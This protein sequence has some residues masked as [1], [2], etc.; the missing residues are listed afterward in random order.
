V[1]SF[2]GRFAIALVVVTLFSTI[3]FVGGQAYGR[4][5]FESESKV[6]HLDDGVLAPV[7]AGKPAN[8]LLLGSDV[9]PADETPQEAA[10]Y[11]TA[12]DTGGARSDVMMILHLDPAAHRSMLVSFPRDLVVQIPGHGLNLLN[13]AYGFGGPALVI[14]TLEQNFPPMKVNHYLEV[15]FRGFKKIVNTIGHVNIYFPTPAN[16]EFTGLHV[17]QA[18]C[19]SLN[20]DEALAY[21]RSRHYNIPSD[22]RNPAPWRPSGANM[23]SPGWIQDGR[24]DLDRIPRQQYFLRTLSRA[25]VK[26]AGTD[27]LGIN[28]L[29]TAIFKNLAHDQYLSYGE[30]TSLAYTFRDLNPSKVDMST[31][32]VANSPYREFPA[33]VVAKFPDAGGV[34]NQLASFT[35]PKKPIVKPMSAD[36]IKVRVINGSGA[37]NAAAHVLDTFLAAGFHS[38]GP[39]A[40]ADR[41][42]YDT[43]VRYAPGKF[44]EGYT[45]AVA[46]GTI[47]LVEAPSARN[48]FG[49]DVLV[50]VGR[51][52][53]TL[54]HRFDLIPRPANLP[55]P[56]STTTFVAPRTTT[57]T[58]VPSTTIDSS[59]VPVD[60]HTGGTL[61]GCPAK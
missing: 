51:D 2:L 56:S 55:P 15:D 37:K 59:F 38:G 42:D 32:P 14:R 26:K 29:L 28:S 49:G 53:D 9:R 43:E 24:A 17:S 16:D 5:K 18:G 33:Q 52:Y 40:D 8:F 12:K 19:V 35:P 46:V 10:A 23:T 11:G 20:G 30:I 34:I 36:R 41:S 54:R 39:P 7:E 58:T 61:V 48:T 6:I 31:L 1:I 50:I 45:A 60:P 3:A 57:S 44:R 13:A 27:P 47:H 21:A 22:L 25:A 4:R